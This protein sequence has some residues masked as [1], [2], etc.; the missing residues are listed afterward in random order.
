MDLG[1]SSEGEIMGE[2][3][4]KE[5]KFN[6]MEELTEIITRT[7]IGVI[8]HKDIGDIVDKQTN[9]SEN[10]VHDFKTR[11]RDQEM[12]VSK[13]LQSLLSS[14]GKFDGKDVTKYLE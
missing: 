3:R 5:F 7:I 2:S 12:K 9:K 13:C 4:G 6:N 1:F 10:R 14:K 8:K 11:S